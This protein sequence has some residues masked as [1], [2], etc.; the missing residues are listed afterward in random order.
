MIKE[1]VFL[2]MVSDDIAK[3]NAIQSE[4]GSE[5]LYRELRVRYLTFYPNFDSI[6]QAGGKAAH[7]GMEFDYRPELRCIRAKLETDIKL[8]DYPTK[9]ERTDCKAIDKLYQ[10][11]I[12]ISHCS[13]DRK[14]GDALRDLIVA[15]GVMNHQLIYTSHPLHKIPLD[16][17]I[18][19]YLRDS[20][21][22]DKLYMI[23]LWS[24]KY[25][26]SPSCL[27]EMGAAW[28]TKADYTNIYV[29]DFHFGNP[30]YHECAVDTRKMGAVLNGDGHCRSNMIELKQKVQA[31]FDLNDDESQSSYYL[32]EFMKKIVED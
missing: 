30:K 2:E 28:V 6:I 31:L 1:E 24:D 7:G 18:Y 14:Y 32:D 16:M 12:F 21:N 19:D 27:N 5:N 11:I 10:P 26:N 22:N 13:A 9:V 3:I 20:I 17:N 4:V 15:F 8:K 23:F 25:L 29:P